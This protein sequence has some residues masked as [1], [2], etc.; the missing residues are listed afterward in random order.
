MYLGAFVLIIMVAL[1]VVCF[2][3]ACYCLAE[4]ILDRRREEGLILKRSNLKVLVEAFKAF[5]MRNAL[6]CEF[7]EIKPFVKEAFRQMNGR[8]PTD[9][10]LNDIESNY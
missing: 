6:G 4:E 2:F 7:C 8:E 9:K 10:E 5:T 3:I 1:F